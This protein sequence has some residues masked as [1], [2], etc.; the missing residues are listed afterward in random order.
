MLL[1]LPL[2]EAAAPSA[3]A[4]SPSSRRSGERTLLRMRVNSLDWMAGVLAGLECAFDDPPPDELRA[5]VR[6]LSERLAACA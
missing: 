6:A 4:R 3:A 1:D 5:S 2:E